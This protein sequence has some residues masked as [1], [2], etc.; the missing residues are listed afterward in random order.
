MSKLSTYCV[1]ASSETMF[2][3][4]KSQEAVLHLDETT[5]DWRLSK[6]PITA[7]LEEYYGSR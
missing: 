5:L 4:S 1:A 2:K 6:R 3:D 7:K